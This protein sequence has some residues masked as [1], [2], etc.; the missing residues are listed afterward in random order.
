MSEPDAFEFSQR[1]E[2]GE[3]AGNV[4]LGKL[5]AMYEELFAE[6]IEDGI[7]TQE[8]RNQLD[9]MADSLGLDRAQP[10]DTIAKNLAGA[11]DS[12]AH[13]ALADDSG[14]GGRTFEKDDWRI[15]PWSEMDKTA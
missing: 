7:I 15:L 9:K 8:E 13:R 6:V 2:L 1:F 4:R 10:T 3:V 14:N 11:A 5:E 12:R